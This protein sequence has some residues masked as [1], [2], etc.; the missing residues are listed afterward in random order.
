MAAFTFTMLFC[1]VNG[2]GNFIQDL[3]ST[4]GFALAVAGLASSLLDEAACIVRD[5]GGQS[6]PLTLNLNCAQTTAAPAD[7]NRNAD[8]VPRRTCQA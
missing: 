5:S 6:S 4:S 2:S 1:L 3:A 8:I 7:E